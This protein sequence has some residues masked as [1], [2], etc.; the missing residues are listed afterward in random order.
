MMIAAVDHCHIDGQVREASGCV[1]AAKTS[2]DNNYARTALLLVFRC[3]G[4]FTHYI[5]RCADGF[6]SHKESR[7]IWL[8]C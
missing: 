4:Q 2:A 5:N 7:T 6:P 3:F 8:I 1:Q